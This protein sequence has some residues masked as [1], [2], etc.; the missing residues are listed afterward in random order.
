MRQLRLEARASRAF[1]QRNAA[2]RRT[3]PLEDVYESLL[4]AGSLC[5]LFLPH[6][7]SFKIKGNKKSIII[8]IIPAPEELRCCSC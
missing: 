4:T 3:A 2:V 6:P 8:H 1:H 7:C 5:P